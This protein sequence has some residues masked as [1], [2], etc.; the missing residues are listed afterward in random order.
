MGEFAGF[1][2]LIFTAVWG[3]RFLGLQLEAQRLKLKSG[4]T[5]HGLQDEIDQLHR[6]LEKVEDELRFYTELQAGGASSALPPGP[7]GREHGADA[8]RSAGEGG[9][10]GQTPA[11]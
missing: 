6:R 7:T 5:D 1:V 8:P 10:D 2:M 9:G 11:A 4:P 3:S